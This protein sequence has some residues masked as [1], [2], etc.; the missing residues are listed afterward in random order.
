MLYK[1]EVSFAKNKNEIQGLESSSPVIQ[2][3]K[4]L[5]SKP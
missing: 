2:A 3:H 1:I 4:V 5:L